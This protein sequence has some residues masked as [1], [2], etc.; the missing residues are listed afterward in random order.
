[1]SDSSDDARL[2]KWRSWLDKSA[3]P[4]GWDRNLW[5]EFYALLHRRAMWRG[6]RVMIESS[7]KEALESARFLSQWVLRN[8]IETQAL[9]VRR[10]A[11]RT[12]DPRS[13]S[14]VRILDEIAAEPQIIGV[15]GNEAKPDADALHSG[16]EK[17]S[18]FANKVV[19]HLDREHAAAS[20]DVSLARMDEVVDQIGS[21]WEKWYVRVTGAYAPAIEPGM[22]GWETILRLKRRDPSI[23][24]PAY[25][26]S[27]VTYELGE[28][29][30]QELLEVLAGTDHERA[31][32]IARLLTSEETRW[33]AGILRDV[34]DDE[35]AR[36]SLVEALR[37]T[38]RVAPPGR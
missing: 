25:V 30:A 1:M 20:R 31:D 12:N 19:A 34:E 36:M 3:I 9:A 37:G 13:V 2:A 4:E 23:L 28:P 10:I 7:S 38:P 11:N 14:L 32:M 17:V 33:L 18:V 15:D 22:M 21:M 27:R 35:A 26:A 16:A 8:H 5:D 6:Y 29:L 24:S